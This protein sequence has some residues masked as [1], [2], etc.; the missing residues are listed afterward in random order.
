MDI[1]TFTYVLYPW[2]RNFLLP[3]HFSYA[4]NCSVMGITVLYRILI[5][6]NSN[7]NCC[8]LEKYF[9]LKKILSGYQLC[10][11]VERNQCLV[12][13]SVPRVYVTGYFE[14][15]PY[16]PAQNH[17]SWLGRVSCLL[18][19]AFLSHWCFTGLFRH[20]SHRIP[21]L[22]QDGTSVSI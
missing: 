16:I 14:C 3:F 11:M 21:Y 15:P 8:S 6:R 7:L 20:V 2:K 1:C 17:C 10:Q 18:C 19:L 9:F 5:N 22:A 4:V 12:T 13:F